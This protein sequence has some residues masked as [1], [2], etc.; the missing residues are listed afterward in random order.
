MKQIV[1]ISGKGGTGKTSITAGLA[2]AASGRV[3]L[4]DCD[5]D[6]ADLHLVLAPKVR[7]T[8]SFESGVLAA[9]DPD[10]CARCGACAEA[11]RF[12]AVSEDFQVRPGH[13]EGCGACAF[14]CPAGAVTL[15]PRRCGEWYESETRC[16]PMVHAALDIGA[17]NSGRLVS[18][19]RAES[20]RL[21]KERGLDFVLV[22]GS[23]GI[24]CP[25]IAGCANTAASRAC[26]CTPSCPWTRASCRPSWRARAWPSWTP[27]A[28]AGKWP[29]SGTCWPGPL[30]GNNPHRCGRVLFSPLFPAPDLFG[31]KRPCY[32][33]STPSSLGGAGSW[34]REGTRAARIGI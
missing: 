15:A 6:A 24:G 19:V 23:P 25:V 33:R 8:H 21:A 10:L 30:V 26:R 14:V 1:V 9:I 18:L 2:W 4:A 13:C 29:A 3:V 28:W 16:G 5:V 11:C 22:D 31:R 34:H 12:G 32:G 17:E 27:R 20:E 7:A